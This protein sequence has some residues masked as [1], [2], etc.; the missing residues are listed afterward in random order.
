MSRNKNVYLPVDLL[1]PR[2]IQSNSIS[3]VKFNGY[4]CD[5]FLFKLHTL[6]LLCVLWD[7]IISIELEISRYYN[8]I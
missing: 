2:C 3:R 8:L 7:V 1:I 4:R 6:D 5:R